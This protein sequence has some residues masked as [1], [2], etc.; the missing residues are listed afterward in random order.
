MTRPERFGLSN[1]SSDKRQSPQ[2]TGLNQITHHAEA[3]DQADQED[4]A[5]DGEAALDELLDRR[6]EAPQQAGHQEKPYAAGG[7][8]GDDENHKIELRGTA[9]AGDQPVGNR[10]QADRKSTRMN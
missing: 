7:D 8:R 9:G 3:T 6:A 5:D 2:I 4:P 10:R 1:V